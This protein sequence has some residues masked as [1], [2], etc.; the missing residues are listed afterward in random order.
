M[1]PSHMKDGMFGVA[2]TR[3]GWFGF[4]EMASESATS[5][6]RLPRPVTVWMSEPESSV[7]AI[8][9]RAHRDLRRRDP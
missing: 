1:R 6:M 2:G 9:L 4:A 3:A 7:A 5:F 8:G